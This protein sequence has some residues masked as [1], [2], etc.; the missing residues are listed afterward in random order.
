[1]PLKEGNSQ[2]T[3]SENIKTERA[4][5]KPEAQAV[6]IA[7]HKAHDASSNLPDCVT[8]QESVNVGKKYGSWDR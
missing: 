3:I 1:M 6:A 7:E 4:A 2:E 8:A 5:G